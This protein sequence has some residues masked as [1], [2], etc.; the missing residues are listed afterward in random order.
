MPGAGS[1]PYAAMPHLVRVNRLDG[2]LIAAAEPLPHSIA[3]HSGRKVPR[4][5]LTGEGKDAVLRGAAA[6]AVSGVLSPRFGLLFAGDEER[7]ERDPMMARAAKPEAV[8]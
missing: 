2:R 1:R 3:E 8:A 6:L 7:A 5:T 4:L